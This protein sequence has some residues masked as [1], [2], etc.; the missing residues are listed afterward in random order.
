VRITDEDTP[1]PTDA[2]EGPVPS[3]QGMP[4]QPLAD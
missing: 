3:E 2:A 1:A 4:D